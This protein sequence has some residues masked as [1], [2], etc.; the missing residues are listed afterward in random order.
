MKALIAAVTAVAV[1]VL[2]L[3]IALLLVIGA[4][5]GGG[6]SAASAATKALPQALVQE[7]ESVGTLSGVPWQLILATLNTLDSSVPNEIS[8]TGALDGGSSV[9]GIPSAWWSK[10][11]VSTSKGHSPSLSSIEDV[12]ETLG[13]FYATEQNDGVTTPSGMVA[14]FN[15]SETF[16]NDVVTLAESYGLGVGSGSAAVT[17]PPTG[18]STGSGTPVNLPPGGPVPAG[19]V[20]SLAYAPGPI[21]KGSGKAFVTAAETQLGVPYVYGGVSP[22]VGVDCSGLV[23]VGMELS[24]LNPNMIAQ[25]FRT[26]EEQVTMGVTVQPSQIQPGD[27][28]FF[29]GDPIDPNPGHVAIALSPGLMLAAPETGENVQ[30]QAIPWGALE[31]ARRVLSHP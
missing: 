23:V 25:G 14:T 27:L 30:I 6:Q 5:L 26:S 21:V 10:W 20:Y 11:G 28:L 4:F 9:S 8:P 19:I 7:T 18:G 13:S 1:F 17:P 31:I 2:A 24:G 29:A 15:P 12:L 22:G 3:P 16:V